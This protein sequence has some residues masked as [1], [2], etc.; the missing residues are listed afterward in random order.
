MKRILIIIVATFIFSNLVLIK[1]QE[2]VVEGGEVN[3]IEVG[4]S[5]QNDVIRKFGD[6]YEL[7]KHNSYS[8][9]LKYEK[10]GLSFFYCQSN[11]NQIIFAIQLRKPF[12]AVT[13]GIVLGESR[14][15][16]V[17]MFYGEPEQKEPRLWLDY[18]GIDF[19]NVNLETGK[20]DLLNDETIIN[21]FN[22]YSFDFKLCNENSSN[23]KKINE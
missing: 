19:R 6:D 16:D 11:E 1:A 8:K 21:E 10:L 20:V 4:R 13:R 17:M 14:A 2:T 3:G 15:K 22:I 7:I 12:K 9:Q 23:H 5:N 18:K